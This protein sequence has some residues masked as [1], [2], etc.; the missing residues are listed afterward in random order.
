MA[1]IVPRIQARVKHVHNQVTIERTTIEMTLRTFLT[2]GVMADLPF[3]QARKGNWTGNVPP[4]VVDQRP[5][6]T[7]A[8]APADTGSVRHLAWAGSTIGPV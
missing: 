8:V 6:Q 7:A 3:L 2:R 1:W 4:G 5:L